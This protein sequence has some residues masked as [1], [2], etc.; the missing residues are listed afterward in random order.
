[1]F[2]EA[3]CGMELHMRGPAGECFYSS[4][5][6]DV[7]PLVLAGTGTGLAPLYGIARDALNQGH[8]GPIHLYHGARTLAQLYYVHELQA[9]V[10]AHAKF[11]YHPCVSEPPP[12]SGTGVLA[13]RL[14]PHVDA[15][16]DTA[17]LQQTQAYLCGAPDF[18]YGMR[19]RIYLKGI[20]A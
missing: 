18:V 11:F 14:E 8:Q 2:N 3:A 9:L 19:K 15:G 16:L 6:G 1:L 13:G 4:L 5:E 10:Q 12:S 17:K 7:H 20:R